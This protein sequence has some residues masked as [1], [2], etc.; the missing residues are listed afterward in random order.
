MRS[1]NK[2][3]FFGDFSFEVGNE[4]YAPAE[5]T[6]FFAENLRVKKGS[7]VVDMGT[8]SGILGILAAEQAETVL[9]VDINPF[10]IQCAKQNAAVNN[11]SCNMFFLRGD[12]F[13]SLAPSVTF[14]LILFNAPYLPSDRDDYKS[15]LGRAWAGGTTGREVI[16]RFISQ[17]PQH[18]AE[19]GEILLVQ[20]NLANLQE[21]KEKFQRSGM[22]ADA[23][24]TLSLPFFETLYLLKVTFL[25]VFQ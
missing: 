11:V 14:N 7:R 4:V 8:G 5:D 21:T 15:W 23:V 22:K 9:A 2:K 19:K 18:L 13:T 1:A 24:A 12:L 6:F 3:T 16:D 25:S 20:S 10:A 17:A